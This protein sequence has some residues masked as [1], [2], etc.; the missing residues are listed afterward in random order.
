[1]PDSI[2]GQAGKVI[3]VTVSTIKVGLDKGGLCG[4]PDRLSVSFKVWSRHKGACWHSHG[5]SHLVSLGTRRSI[6]TILTI[7]QDSMVPLFG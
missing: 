1:M 4:R 6:E 2:T 3:P 7:Q 5:Q